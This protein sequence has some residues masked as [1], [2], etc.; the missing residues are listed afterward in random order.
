MA[1]G[2]AAYS[3]VGPI[4]EVFLAKMKIARFHFPSLDS[5]NSFVK[6]SV[7]RL[8]PNVLSVV[9]ADEQKSGRGR[10]GR[11]W[12]SG[13][14]HDLKMSFGFVIPAPML[15]QAYQLTSLLAVATVEV[16]RAA[17]F[18]YAAAGIKWPNDIVMDGKRKVGG[19]L[20]ELESTPDGTYWAAL[21]LGLNVNSLPAE[22][23]VDRPIWPLSSLRNESEDR[24]HKSGHV[25]SGNSLPYEVSDETVSL[26]AESLAEKMT[27]ELP[28]FFARGFEPFQ[29]R[30]EAYSVL[31]GK[32]IR[33]S[34]SEGPG[35]NGTSHLPEV[36]EGVVEGFETDGRLLLRMAPAD[37]PAGSEEG[38]IRGFLAGEVTGIELIEP[39]GIHQNEAPTPQT[40]WFGK[41]TV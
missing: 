4:C 7:K 38:E 3:P 39:E 16:L 37:A 40:G 28:V 9:T 27:H 21:G 41:G 11:Q 20:G 5:T 6:S 8:D 29:K 34:A 35:G 10:L 17:P 1:D 14:K 32:R 31:L 15:R 24:R 26:L 23:G 18:H 25:W 33:F 12:V 19:I 22:L 30:Y 36:H 2:K 13:G